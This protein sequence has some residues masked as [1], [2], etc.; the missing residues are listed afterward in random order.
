M[1]LRRRFKEVRSENKGIFCGGKI[2]DDF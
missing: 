2:N 1:F